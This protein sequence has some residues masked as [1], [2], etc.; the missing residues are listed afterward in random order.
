MLLCGMCDLLNSQM[1]DR[2]LFVPLLYL[3]IIYCRFGKTPEGP[4]HPVL[5]Q[6][7]IPRSQPGV[8]DI[9]C[10]CVTS[11]G[12]FEQ[13]SGL[14][15]CPLPPPDLFLSLG[16]GRVLRFLGEV[17]GWVNFYKMWL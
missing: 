1:T 5:I 17:V 15:M 3:E 4:V 7:Y 12:S 14:P 8:N 2:F 13:K 9:I 16:A 11:S 6:A 10:R